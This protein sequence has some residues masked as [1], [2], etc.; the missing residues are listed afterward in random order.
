LLS[1]G[2]SSSTI[3]L[4]V[5]DG[6]VQRKMSAICSWSPIEA[7][8][9]SSRRTCSGMSSLSSARHN[10]AMPNS[11]SAATNASPSGR[12]RAFLLD[13][14][15]RRD[16]AE[17]VDDA[18]G[19]LGG[20]DLAAQAMLLDRLAE[21][22]LHRPREGGAQLARHAR[23]G[24][25]L[26]RLDCA[27]Q[28]HLGAGQQHRQLRPGQAA[29]LVDPAQQLLVAFQPLDL[30][31][32]AAAFLQQLDRP[33]QRRHRRAP[34]ALGDGQASVWRRLSSSTRSETSSVICARN[35]L[36]AAS[37]SRP[38]IISR[39]SGIL[40]F[41]SLS[42]QSTPALLS[43]KSVFTRPPASANSIRAACVM[44]RLAPSPIDLARS[45]DASTRTGSLPGSPP[46]AGSRPTP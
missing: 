40:M 27:L 31:V 17:P 5:S 10:S 38:S 46:P 24:G 13:Q 18:V 25:H 26:A 9:N 41:T 20:D 30:P 15:E 16:D 21:P 11:R 4:G 39:L 36:R 35:S 14:A 19:D 44:A 32:E 7:W 33:H 22:L 6:D 23:V 45:S 8:S 37:S 12:R 2:C 43:M 1:P 3:W 34:A 29:I 28:L 42:E